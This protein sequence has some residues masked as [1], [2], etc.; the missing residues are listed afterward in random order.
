MPLFAELP[1]CEKG[2]DGIVSDALVNLDNVNLAM[3]HPNSPGKVQ[4]R[5]VSGLT[6]TLAMSMKDFAEGVRAARKAEAK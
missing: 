2:P 6:L 3:A 5:M 4:I 1:M